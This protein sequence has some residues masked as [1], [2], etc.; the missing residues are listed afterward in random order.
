MRKMKSTHTA[1]FPAALVEP[2]ILATCPPGGTVLDPFSGSGT[3]GRVAARAGR[4]AILI[5]QSM[6]AVQDSIRL[7]PEPKL[8][9]V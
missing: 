3:V 8:G 1:P 5:E 2:C 6:D 4:K 9:V 7:M